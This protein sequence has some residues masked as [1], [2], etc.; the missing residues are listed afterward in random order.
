MTPFITSGTMSPTKIGRND[1]WG[2]PQALY[3]NLDAE[4]HFEIDLCANE[5]NHKH[6][7]Y[8]TIEDDS[9][10]QSWDGL[11]AYGN[12]PYGRGLPAWTSKA[13]DSALRGGAL[14]VALIPCRT[15]TRWWGDC[16]KANEIRLIRGRL[17]YNDGVDAAPF[18]SCIIVWD[19]TKEK[20]DHPE[21][22][23][24]DVEG[25]AVA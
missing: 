19:G 11:V 3:D 17:H 15:D 5:V 20:P 14:I 4:F 13:A 16:M 12:F 6:P 10:A 8:W 23:W 25:R 18:P 21:L 24:V 22:K 2:T 1:D 9:L 7:R